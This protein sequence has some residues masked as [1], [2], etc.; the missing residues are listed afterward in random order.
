[1]H[2]IAY[3]DGKKEIERKKKRGQEESSERGGR[4]KERV[5]NPCRHDW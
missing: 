1:M 4:E 3:T 5:E 2:A